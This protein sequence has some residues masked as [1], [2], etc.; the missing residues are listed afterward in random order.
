MRAH[1]LADFR[2]RNHD[3]VFL[4]VIRGIR[5]DLAFSKIGAVI[6]EPINL[7]RSL[8]EE[9][10]DHLGA[11]LILGFVDRGIFQLLLCLGNPRRF[12]GFRLFL[13][14][15]LFLRASEPVSVPVLSVFRRD[16]PDRHHSFS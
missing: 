1:I 12:F 14:A 7:P 9:H 2:D 13:S 11:V 10:A 15:P 6:F 16:R 4:S 5:G 8:L 3:F